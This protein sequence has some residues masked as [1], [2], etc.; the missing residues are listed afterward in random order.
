[1]DVPVQAI[2]PGTND[3][4]SLE[5][6]L[7]AITKD[8]IRLKY[9][10]DQTQ[11]E[12]VRLDTGLELNSEV[13]GPR[14]Y[15]DRHGHVLPP[16]SSQLQNRLNQ[17]KEYSEIHQLKIN[18]SKTK[19]MT[20]NFS[21]K[22]D[23]LPKLFIGDN[24]LEVVESA[25]LLGVILSSD[26]KWNAHTKYVVQKT[27]KRL[28]YLRRLCKLGAST[29]T[30]LHMYQ[31]LLRSVLETAAPVFAGGL[32][33]TNIRDFENVQKSAFKII[34]RGNY[35]NYEN[36][37]EL[38]EQDTLEMRR[39]TISYKFAKKNIHHPK[40]RHLFR[41]K[42]SARTRSKSK[43]IEPTFKTNRGQK[44]PVSYLIRLLNNDLRY[45]KRKAGSK[46]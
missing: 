39:N 46:L 35:I 24:Q 43:F 38:L 1:M 17:I 22:Y 16:E 29:G 28:W 8:E 4:I 30:L 5:S 18:E 36:A 9:V 26:L 33:K 44:G 40:M 19:V 12:V 20:F 2:A 23:F 45:K 21:N 7:P 11:G 34:L 31:V 32:T 42:I 10:D 6:P 41:K 14:L 13:K 25:K 27:K 3:V 15:H 37:L